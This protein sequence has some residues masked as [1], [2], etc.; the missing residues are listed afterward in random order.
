MKEKAEE[1]LNKVPGIRQI[2]ETNLTE[3]N[4]K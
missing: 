3:R 1:K 4:W 2:E